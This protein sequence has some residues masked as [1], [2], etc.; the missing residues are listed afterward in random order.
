MKRLGLYSL[1]TLFANC[2]SNPKDSND[3]NQIPLKVNFYIERKYDSLLSTVN[4]EPYTTYDIGISIINRSDSIKSFWIMKCAWHENFIISDNYY[5]FLQPECNG[6]YPTVK[7]IQP[8]DSLTFKTTIFSRTISA[9]PTS[10][11]IKL[12]FI[13]LDE[14]YCNTYDDYLRIM[15]DKSLHTNVL[16]SDKIGL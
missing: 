15:R 7:S 12:G 3:N 13:L 5:S 4:H 9:F 1:L 2:Y 8:Q 6:N 10:D 14:K 16:W 11:S